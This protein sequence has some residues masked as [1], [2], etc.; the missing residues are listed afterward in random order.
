MATF[1]GNVNLSVNGTLTSASV[2][3]GSASQSLN[4]SFKQ[5]FANGTAANQANQMFADTRSI[6]GSSDDDLDL[7]GSLVDGIGNTITFT[8]IKAIIIHAASTNG[9]AL[10]VGA[11]AA[12]GFTTFFGSSTDLIKIR[13]GGSFM[14]VNPEANG[15]A[16]TAG[17]ADKF[18]ISNQDASTASFDIVLIGEV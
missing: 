18:R 12:N 5:A 13:P 8:S 2:D 14:I 7:A 4:T 15:Y 9:D 6:A 1:K 10:H 3:L 16:V 17:T 11:A